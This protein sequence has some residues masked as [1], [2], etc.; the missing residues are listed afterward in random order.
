MDAK[1][2]GKRIKGFRKLKGYTQ[3]ELAKK[4]NLSLSQLGDIERGVKEASFDMIAHIAN[5]LHIDENEITLANIHGNKE[6]ICLK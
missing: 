2:I 4:L 1:R 6:D 3:A 5:G